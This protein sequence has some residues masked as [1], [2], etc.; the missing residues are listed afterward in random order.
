MN[1]LDKQI[2][3]EMMASAMFGPKGA[4]NLRNGPNWWERRTLGLGWLLYAFTRVVEPELVVEAGAG[5]SSFCILQALKDNGH[6]HLYTIDCWPVSKPKQEGATRW[7]PN[8]EPYTMEHEWFLDML[9]KHEME[10]ICTLHYGK[11]EEVA[12]T[13]D[14]PI[15]MLM[16][17][18]SHQSEETRLEI[19][20]FLPHLIP[21]GYAF[22]HDPLV[23]MEAI[24]WQLEKFAKEHD[25]YSIFFEP[26][27]LSMAILQ[28][29]FTLDF[30]PMWVAGNLT[31]PSNPQFQSTPFQGTHIRALNAL[32]PWE[33]KWFPTSEETSKTHNAMR[34][35]A[36]EIV[37]SGEEQTP[38]YINERIQE[39]LKREEN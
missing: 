21:G 9:K 24:G 10:D 31:Q 13:W 32:K 11:S 18:S 5:G 29:K 33:E 26:D 4:D 16:V 23:C 36:D 37:A 14:K 20:G 22:F 1:P 28:R 30:A 17:D 19:N 2:P 7:F 8:G 34:K 6:G 35:L 25:D 15:E 38:A 12:R 39:T 3:I 27:F